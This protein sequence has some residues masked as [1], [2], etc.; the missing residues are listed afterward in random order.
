M[1]RVK[2]F[3]LMRRDHFRQIGAEPPERGE[4]ASQR[5]HLLTIEAH[6]KE[7][8]VGTGGNRLGEVVASSNGKR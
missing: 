4:A 2:A 6:N 3:F 5:Q 1:S 7:H 8:L